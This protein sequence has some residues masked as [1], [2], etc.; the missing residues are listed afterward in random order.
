M[1]PSNTRLSFCLQESLFHKH[2]LSLGFHNAI[3]VTEEDTRLEG[4]RV[5]WEIFGPCLRAGV[6]SFSFQL[7]S[8]LCPLYD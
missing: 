6:I 8:D 1:H 5:R 2:L 3:R 7:A 4:A